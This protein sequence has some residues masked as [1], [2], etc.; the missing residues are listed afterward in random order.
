M[1]TLHS[2]KIAD[3]RVFYALPSEVQMMH[4]AHVSNTL[5]G[6]YMGDGSSD[7]SK[8]KKTID[9][10]DLMASIADHHHAPPSPSVIEHARWILSVPGLAASL[11]RDARQTLERAG[12]EA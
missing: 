11:Y 8:P 5:R 3:P 2:L 12:V 4:M 7:G 9:A 1:E 10:Q 6:A